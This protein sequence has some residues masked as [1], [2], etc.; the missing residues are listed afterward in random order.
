MFGSFS[1]TQT[2]NGLDPKRTVTHIEGFSS[3]Y[4]IIKKKIL[5]CYGHHVNR[6]YFY[7][8]QLFHNGLFSSRGLLRDQHRKTEKQASNAYV[9]DYWQEVESA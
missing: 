9:H 2:Y 1:Q 8:L 3:K 6:T 7:K 5:T 4:N